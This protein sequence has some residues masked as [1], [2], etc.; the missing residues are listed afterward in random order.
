MRIQIQKI[1]KS[2]RGK[3]V[4]LGCRNSYGKQ[5]WVVVT[6]FA[7]GG[8]LTAS[9]FVIQDPGSNNRGNLQQFLGIYPQFYKFF[10]Y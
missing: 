8:K 9:D 3:P 4:L 2:Y 7:G 5:H 6:G 10:H 1:K